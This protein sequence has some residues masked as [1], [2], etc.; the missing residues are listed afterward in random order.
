MVGKRL[1]AGLG[2][3]HAVNQVRGSLKVSRQSLQGQELFSNFNSYILV[4]L[5]VYIK[6]GHEATGRVIEFLN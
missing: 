3:K 2:S 1:V 5:Q 6:L 4:A